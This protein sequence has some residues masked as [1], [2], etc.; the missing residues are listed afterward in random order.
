MGSIRRRACQRGSVL[1][2][3]ACHKVDPLLVQQS[4]VIEGCGSANQ[5]TRVASMKAL[6]QAADIG[7]DLR[8]L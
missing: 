4:H 8:V 2:G 1:S 7:Q 5:H 3:R 6:D